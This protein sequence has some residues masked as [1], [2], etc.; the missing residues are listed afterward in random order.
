[1]GLLFGYLPSHALPFA[2]PTYDYVPSTMH[3]GGHAAQWRNSTV[4]V[5]LGAAN[6]A[7][8]R[9]FLPHGQIWPGKNCRPESRLMGRAAHRPSL[10]RHHLRHMPR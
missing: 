3:I 9:Q 2:G 7:P 10:F 5:P 8:G 6:P 4:W 1:M